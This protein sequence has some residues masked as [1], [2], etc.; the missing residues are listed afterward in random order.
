MPD[1]AA[2]PPPPSPATATAA[3]APSLAALQT[4][5]A[6]ARLSVVL[7]CYNEEEN[8]PSMVERLRRVADAQGGEWEFLFVDDH[9][10][11]RTPEVLRALAAQDPR[12]K[13]IRFARN[14]GS[15]AAIAAGLAHSRGDAAVILASDGQDP[16]EDVPRMVEKWRAGSKVVWAVRAARHDAASVK[17]FS[18]AYWWLMQKIALPN[19]P[20]AGADMLLVDRRVIDVVDR[21]KERNTTI[22]GVILW[23][24]FDQAFVNYT[25]EPRRHG[26]TKWTFARK[27]KLAVDSVVSFSYVPI[28][29]MSYLGFL[30]SLLGF[31]YAALVI[32]RAFLVKEL[33]QGWSSLMSVFLVVSGVQMVMLG[34]LGEYLWRAL[35]ETRS[36]PRYIVE[37]TLNVETAPG[38]EGVR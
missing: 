2:G 26:A 9:S 31:L 29:W 28:R 33:P 37:G 10:S 1:A 32:G 16:P 6:G 17:L 20:P 23:A 8:L 4:P 34:M 30:L 12:V 11:D 14:F 36:R 22:L 18:W 21:M 5:A 35:D 15:H 3:A 7:P 25:K 27:V 19:M 13:S 24:G 38:Q